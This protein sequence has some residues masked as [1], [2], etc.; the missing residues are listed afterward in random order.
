MLKTLI[1]Y[2]QH[3]ARLTGVTVLLVILVPVWV[4]LNIPLYILLWRQR[5]RAPKA[6]HLAAFMSKLNNK[7]KKPK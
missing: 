4:L 3:T 1:H 2:I 7:N 5:A 6:L